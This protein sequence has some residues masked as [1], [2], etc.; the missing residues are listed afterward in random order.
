MALFET[1]F[2]SQTL[3]LSLGMNIILPEHPDAWKT[4]PAVLYLLHGLSDDHTIWSRRT[5]IERHAQ[6]YPLVIVMPDVHKS[7]YCNMAHGSDYWSFIA[8]ELPELVQ[9]WFNVAADP[10]RTFVAG[11][12]MG[13]YG[14]MKL[15][16]GRPQNFSAA[17]SLSGALNIAA[18]IHDEF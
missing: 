6:N 7:F 17:A 18:H 15:A 1:R 8:D 13:G 2:D 4:P 12:S 5:A 16:L 14:A 9:R 11:L 3:E 10:A